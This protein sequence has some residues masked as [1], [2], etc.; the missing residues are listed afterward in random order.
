MR[1]RL[2]L[3]LIPFRFGITSIKTPKDDTND[4][5]SEATDY[6]TNRWNGLTE[7]TRNNEWDN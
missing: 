7:I 2:A 5:L 4:S 3:S 6:R 1:A